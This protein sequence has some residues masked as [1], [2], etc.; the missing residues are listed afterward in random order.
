MTE[1]CP[2][3]GASWRC[4]HAEALPVTRVLEAPGGPVDYYQAPE[5]RQPK[6]PSPYPDKKLL[7][8]QILAVVSVNKADVNGRAQWW[9]RDSVMRELG[10]DTWQ[11]P[12]I[13]QH[14]NAVFLLLKKRGQIME[15]L[16]GYVM[17][18]NPLLYEADLRARHR[19]ALQS[20]RYFE[21][22][23]L[24][25]E[26]GIARNLKKAEGIRAELESL[27]VKP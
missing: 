3:C 2:K 26:K 12:G 18:P 9:T 11:Q 7:E 1:L 25:A 20:V 23:R 21:L 24:G 6:E 15:T 13:R 5:P 14:C 22:A 4:E 16:G 27:G 8:A 19:D 10:H 17:L